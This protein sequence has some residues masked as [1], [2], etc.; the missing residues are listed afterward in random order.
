MS[1]RGAWRRLNLVLLRPLRRAALPL[2]CP[3]Q[4]RICGVVL[5]R[6]SSFAYSFPSPFGRGV[7]GEGLT[8]AQPSRRMALARKDI[9]GAFSPHILSCVFIPLSLWER[10]QGRGPHARAALPLVCPAQ[11]RKCGV[12][13]PRISSFAYSFPSPF[14]RGLRVRASRQAG[15]ATWTYAQESIA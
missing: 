3:A 14:G 6:I 11:K 4:K 8:H 12:L 1:L 5:P 9:R 13:L 10:G 7:R 2:I 15:A